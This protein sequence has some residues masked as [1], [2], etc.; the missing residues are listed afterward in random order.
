MRGKNRL[1]S[2]VS[3]LTST[4]EEQGFTLIEVL[5]ASAIVVASIGVL[6][7]LFASGLDRMHRAGEHAHLILAERQIVNDLSQINPAGTARGEGDAEGFHYRWS[8]QAAS[9]LLPIYD[10]EGLLHRKA[11]IYDVR[12]T[13]MRPDH[14]KAELT[15][16]RLGWR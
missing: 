8:A 9:S 13:I 6:M 5:V 3:P 7:Q 16:K 15:L 1:T 4:S 14:G 2:H 10:P 12:V 11:A